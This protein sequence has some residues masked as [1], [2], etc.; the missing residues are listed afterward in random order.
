MQKIEMMIKQKF[1]SNFFLT[2]LL[3]IC[4]LLG[5]AQNLVPNGGF[6]EGNCMGYPGNLVECNDWFSSLTPFE[7]T[8]PEW[9]HSCIDDDNFSTPDVAF[10][11]QIPFDQGY[12][13]LAIYPDSPV[14]EAANYRE[15][16][17]V[18]LTQSLEEGAFYLVQFKFSPIVSSQQFAILTN[19]FGFNFSTHPHYNSD[20]FP[21]NTSHYAIDTIVPLSEDTAWYEISEVFEA[22]SAYEYLHIGN[23][24]SDDQTSTTYNSENSFLAYYVV[25]QVSVS[26]TLDLPENL[27]KD[28]LLIYPNPTSDNLV[29]SLPEIIEYGILTV[30]NLEGVN[31]FE[32]QFS[33]GLNEYPIDVTGLRA[34]TYFIL[35]ETPKLT[36]HEKF[37]KL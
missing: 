21:I 3:S 24:Y 14:P 25:D 19:N 10:G 23:F 22:D 35:I 13:G 9:F 1:L 8:T 20:G 2:T 5:Q 33:N 34:G 36:I 32:H 17:G 28:N 26:L 37:I 12:A 6:E 29:I 27:Q 11:S 15:I 16:I 18:Q 30:C 31:L 4:T 7:E